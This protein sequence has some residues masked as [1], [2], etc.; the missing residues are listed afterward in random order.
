MRIVVLILSLCLPAEGAQCQE[1]QTLCGDLCSDLWVSC[2][3]GQ[4]VLK[5]TDKP[6][7]EYCCVPPTPQKAS[8]TPTKQC[9]YDTEGDKF[10]DVTCEDGTVIPTSQQCDKSI[11]ITKIRKCY[12]D[13]EDSQFLGNYAHYTCPDGTCLPLLDMCQGYSCSNKNVS[14]CGRGLRCIDNAGITKLSS[15]IAGDHYYCYY[16]GYNNDGVYNRLDRSD[17]EILGAKKSTRFT[18]ELKTCKN[19]AGVTCGN[20]CMANYRCINVE[21]NGNKIINFVCT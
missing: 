18:G 21:Q 7:T 9:H 1:W 19:N 15:K 20:N 13:Y 2:K 14:E 8:L 11:V 10:S 16:S 3:C 17:E 12:N 5:N 4:E 6:K